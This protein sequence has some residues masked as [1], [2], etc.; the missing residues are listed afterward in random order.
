ML[1]LDARGRQQLHC[2]NNC[3]LTGLASRYTPPVESRPV[4]VDPS[5][6]R[7]RIMRKLGIAAAS[8]LVV[9]LGAIVVAMAGGPQAPL[10][11]WA[12][13]HDQRSG[14]L[15]GTGGAIRTW[16]AP[17]WLT[18]TRSGH[19]PTRT[20][21]SP[22]PPDGGRDSSLLSLRTRWLERS[23][24]TPACCECRTLRNP[25]A[26]SAADWR[27]ARQ[28]G[29]DGYVIVLTNLDT[30]DW[31][32][33]GVKRIVA[34]ATPSGGKGAV[35]MLHDGGGNRAQTV[36]AL[37]R[38]I[39]RLRSKGYRFTAIT[40]GLRQ[41]PGDVPATSRQRFAGTVLAV[42]QQ[43]ADHRSASLPCFS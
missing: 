6:R 36:A 14:A 33:P 17:N 21:A 1:V 3:L 29:L 2:P 13:P 42:T 10:T 38:I 34:A 18:A 30:K 20:R 39:T 37:A 41:P 9:C 11:N 8:V 31:T 40:N 25:D 12:A 35:I 23:A 27:A 32:R 15:P 19:T 24:S 4:F 5:G 43:V 7:H 22:L 26:L 16:C 28:A